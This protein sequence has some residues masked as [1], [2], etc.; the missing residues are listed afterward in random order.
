MD[1]ATILTILK[2]IS[3][4]APLVETTIPIVQAIIAG[5]TV[6]SAQV[7]Q[8]AQVMSALEKIA[9]AKAASITQA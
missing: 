7:A 4:I 2:G 1:I 8:L 3:E 6:S 5:Q 9:D